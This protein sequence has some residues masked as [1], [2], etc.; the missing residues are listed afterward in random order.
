MPVHPCCQLAARVHG[1]TVDVYR[2]S[3]AFAAIAAQLG[4]GEPQA[5]AQHFRQRP[6]VVHFDS[7]RHAIDG[8]LDSGALESSGIGRRS[9]FRSGSLRLKRGYSSSRDDCGSG[10]L[11]EL[12]SGYRFLVPLLAHDYSNVDTFERKSKAPAQRASGIIR[13][14]SK[15]CYECGTV[16]NG[17]E[18]YCDAC[19]GRSW[20]ELPNQQVELSMLN[21]LALLFMLGLIAFSYWLLVWRIPLK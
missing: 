21:W 4:A 7:A 17:E 2:A 18:G 14:M 5:I 19:G 9:C 11:N 3:A 6:A 10:A 13:L 16:T 15:Q 1:F 20:R 8:Q 12:A